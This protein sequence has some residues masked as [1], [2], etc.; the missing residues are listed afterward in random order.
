MFVFP[1]FPTLKRQIA[2]HLFLLGNVLHNFEAVT[3]VLTK[4][5]LQFLDALVLF[6][7]QLFFICT[8]LQLSQL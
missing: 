4:I 2:Y 1:H 7:L 8:S 6:L 5:L 3:L